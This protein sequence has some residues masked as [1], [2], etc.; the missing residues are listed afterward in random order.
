MQILAVLRI[1][2]PG[3]TQIALG[4]LITYHKYDG[5]HARSSR[6]VRS[7]YAALPIAERV[8]P[9]HRFLPPAILIVVV[10]VLRIFTDH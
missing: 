2:T 9:R 7:G 6:G 10:L 3:I 4:V 8:Q 5:I 1:S